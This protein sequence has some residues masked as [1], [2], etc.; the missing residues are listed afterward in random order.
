MKLNLPTIISLV[1]FLGIS[2]FIVY[3]NA[4]QPD[5][6]GQVPAIIPPRADSTATTTPQLEE[7][8]EDKTNLTYEELRKKVL[9]AND[10]LL[11]DLVL[12]DP[13]RVVIQRGEG[14]KRLLFD[15]AFANIGV[16]NLHIY[17]T[18]EE[19]RFSATQILSSTEGSEYH[20]SVG[21]FQFKDDHDHWHLANFANYELWSIGKNGI[22]DDLIA[23]TVKVS[24]CIWDYGEYSDGN[25]NLVSD[26]L[27]PKERQYPKCEH[28]EQGLTIG[29]FDLYDPFTGGQTIDIL[30]VPDGVYILRTLINVNKEIFELGYEN[31]ESSIYI[32]II[33]NA[34][35]ILKQPDAMMKI[36][37]RN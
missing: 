3:A 12:A 34:A 20:V 24:F 6:T 21:D 11:P 2:A 4:A 37:R 25:F 17:S 36:L 32:E 14:V 16:G 27:I 26:K 15:T 1:L 22:R 33:G 5:I 28:E 35:F 23:S 10:L 31:N 19:D 18:E 29:W 7:L 30:D 9:P 8:Q 13:T